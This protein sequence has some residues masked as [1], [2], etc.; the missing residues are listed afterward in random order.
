MNRIPLI[1]DDCL[2]ISHSSQSVVKFSNTTPQIWVFPQWIQS[3]IIHLTLENT[4]KG[5]CFSKRKKADVLF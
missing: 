1:N 4:N 3:S 2:S 5:N